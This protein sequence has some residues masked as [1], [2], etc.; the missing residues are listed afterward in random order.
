MFPTRGAFQ[1]SVSVCLLFTIAIFL[2]RQ[3]QWRNCFSL[4][5]LAMEMIQMSQSCWVSQG[6]EFHRLPLKL[7]DQRGLIN[8]CCCLLLK[9][10][11]YGGCYRQG[12]IKFVDYFTLEVG[13]LSVLWYSPQICSAAYHQR[14]KTSFC[15]WKV[16][17]ATTG[18]AAKMQRHSLL[19]QPSTEKKL[20][21]LFSFCRPKEP[22]VLKGKFLL[23]QGSLSNY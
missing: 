20:F 21:P 11:S 7:E 14:Q 13:K 12:W 2:S 18:S 3:K 4:V 9:H 17:G 22:V 23:L 15:D 5:L 19:C 1:H 10:T 6:K 8:R 16:L